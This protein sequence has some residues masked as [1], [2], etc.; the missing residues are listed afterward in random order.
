MKDIINKSFLLHSNG[1]SDYFS[2]QD[3]NQEETYSYENYENNKESVITDRSADK[4][5]EENVELGSEV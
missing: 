4:N 5:V 2:T 1:D 3:N